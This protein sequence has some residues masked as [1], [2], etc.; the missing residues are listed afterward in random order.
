MHH[1]QTVSSRP[2]QLVLLCMQH[3]FIVHMSAGPSP[4]CREHV[5]EEDHI[6]GHH[7]LVYFTAVVPLVKSEVG[8]YFLCLQSECTVLTAV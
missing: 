3:V 7:R 6:A 1:S 8:C 4:L 5:Q 2:N